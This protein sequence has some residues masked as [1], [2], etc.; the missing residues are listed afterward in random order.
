MTTNKYS[1]GKIYKLV[2]NVDDKEYVGS[3]YQSLSKRKGGHKVAAKT[4]GEQRVY[5]HLNEIGFNNVEIIL[6]ENYPCSSKDEL[7]A[8]ERKWIDELKPDLN[9]QLPCRT[10]QEYS[11][12]YREENAD[13]L[14]VNQ[15][16]YRAENVDKVKERAARYRA[17]NVEKERQRHKQYREE[18]KEAN[19]AKDLERHKKYREENCEIIKAKARMRRALKKAEQQS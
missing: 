6:I 7:N 2:N 13:T 8:R 11:K 14:R 19:H 18:N 4:N 3:T 9:K 10:I 1:T 17:E 12:M 5:K 16:K 15:A